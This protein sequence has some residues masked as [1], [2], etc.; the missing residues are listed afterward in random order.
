MS[1]SQGPKG[2]SPDSEA[3]GWVSCAQCLLAA[4]SW[5]GIRVGAEPVQPASLM[6]LRL[7]PGAKEDN[8]PASR[9]PQEFRAH[10]L[11]L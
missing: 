5:P 9:P 11:G 10:R 8:Y 2:T 1:D 3:L 4:H 7:R 6:W